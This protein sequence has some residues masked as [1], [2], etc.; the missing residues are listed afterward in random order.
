MVTASLLSGTDHTHI[1]WPNY[2]LHTRSADSVI[3]VDTRER[4]EK[5]TQENIGLR[6]IQQGDSEENDGL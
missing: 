2:L 3:Q 1:R 5:E 4:R 6:K